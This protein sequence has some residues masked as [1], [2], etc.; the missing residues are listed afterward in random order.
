[1]R[2]I[3]WSFEG[4]SELVAFPDTQLWRET[5]DESDKQRTRSVCSLNEVCQDMASFEMWRRG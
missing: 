2:E 5:A 1:M 3:D 4:V